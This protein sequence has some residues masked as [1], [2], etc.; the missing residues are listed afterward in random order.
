[1]NEQP[2][3]PGAPRWVKVFGTI[4][5]VIVL[6]FVFVL[7]SRGPHGPGRH[8]SPGGSGAKHTAPPR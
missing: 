8:T 7:H 4:F 1:M 3:Y 5:V 6:L 2:T